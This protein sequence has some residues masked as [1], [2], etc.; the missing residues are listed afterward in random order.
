[1]NEDAPNEDANRRTLVRI[2]FLPGWVVV[3]VT[4]VA[5]AL[6][7]TVPPR[8]RWVPLAA[9][10]V[11]F[12]LPHGAVDHLIVPRVRGEYVTRRWLA[13]VGVVYAVLGSLYATVWF[14]APVAAFGVFIGL[15]WFHWG[16]GEL[17]PL[18]EIAGVEHLRTPGSRVTTAAVRGAIPMGLPLVAFPERFRAVAELL[19]SPF[20][21]GSAGEALEPLLQPETRVAIFVGI[22]GLAACTLAIGGVRARRMDAKRVD[23]NATLGG[24]GRIVLPGDAVR[25]WLLDVGETLLLLGFFGVVP[26]VLAVG[27]YFCVW[28]SLRHVTRMIALDDRSTASLAAGRIVPSLWRFGRDATPL[29]VGALVVFGVLLVIVPR[30]PGTPVELIGAY[31]VTIAVVTLPHAAIVA[32]VDREQGLI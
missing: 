17:Y 16:A 23:A 29:S 31:L 2:T 8:Y 1:M 27:I 18:V 20:A 19:V 7:A 14:T 25:G 26:P 5:F 28:H 22:C 24:E 11:L 6:G 30:T 10:V 15:T 12:G 3:G 4:T 32:R 13:I 21:V 9:S